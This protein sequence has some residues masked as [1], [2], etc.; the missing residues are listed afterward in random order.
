M[1]DIFFCPLLKGKC[2]SYECGWYDFEKSRCA[3]VTIAAMAR[4]E[5]GSKLR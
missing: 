3:V 1:E 4:I 2:K 5:R